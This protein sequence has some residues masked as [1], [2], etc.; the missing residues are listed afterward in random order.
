[1]A[2][3]VPMIKICEMANCVITNPLLKEIPPTVAEVILFFR[4]NAGLNPERINA[5]YKPARTC[6]T[7]TTSNKNNN[8]LP[9]KKTKWFAV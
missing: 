1:M 3:I 7:N 4:A 8:S 9:I 5:G 2:T 6:Y